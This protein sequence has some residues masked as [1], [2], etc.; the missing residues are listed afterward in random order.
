MNEYNEGDLVEA[1]KGETVF[2]ERLKSDDGSR[3]YMPTM[4]GGP[5]VLNLAGMGYT[6]RV[7]EK[8]EEKVEL[9]SE[10]GIYVSRKDGTPV[11][12]HKLTDGRWVNADDTFYMDDDM[13]ERWL[14]LLLLE[15]RAETA[16]AVIEAVKQI[17]HVDGDSRI[18]LRHG[19]LAVADEFGVTK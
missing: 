14:P 17:P 1:V 3:L 6:V 13:V 15:P 2:R 18:N 19:L 7:I 5:H 8:A 9:P 12:I 4:R 11:I 10:P 16:K